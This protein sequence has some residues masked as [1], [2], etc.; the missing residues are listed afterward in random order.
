MFTCTG[1]TLKGK[2]LEVG[3]GDTY[4][5]T[6]EYYCEKQKWILVDEKVR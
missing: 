4:V 1:A 3:L 2:N 6:Y 5:Y